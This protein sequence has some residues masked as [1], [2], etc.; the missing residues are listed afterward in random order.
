MQT[1]TSLPDYR[2]YDK[3]H[4]IICL[5]KNGFLHRGFSR[6]DSLGK[7]GEQKQPKNKWLQPLI[8]FLADRNEEEERTNLKCKMNNGNKMSFR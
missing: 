5:R 3:F 1:N 6:G 2:V 4:S 7:P 8:F